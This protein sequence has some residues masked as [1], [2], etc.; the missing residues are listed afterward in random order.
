MRL[1]TDALQCMSAGEP[2]S[3]HVPLYVALA[4]T[5]EEIFIPYYLFRCKVSVFT[6]SDQK[7]EPSGTKISS[8]DT[9]VPDAEK[10]N[11]RMLADIKVY[12]YFWASE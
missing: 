4:K 2:T 6:A 8:L 3:L 12:S 1:K 5:G 9:M 10:S 11:A 7:K